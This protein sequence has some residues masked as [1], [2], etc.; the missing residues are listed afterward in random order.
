MDVEELSDDVRTSTPPDRIRTI[1]VTAVAYIN[2]DLDA[3][4]DTLVTQSPANAE[5][6]A[7]ART[8]V[9]HPRG[10]IDALVI[11]AA[12][13]GGTVLTSDPDDLRALA[14][15]ARAVRIVAV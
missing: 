6:T 9:R 1:G 12:E 4:S 8:E 10:P 14:G 5:S 11:A 7:H 3:A 2:N 15:Y 13:P